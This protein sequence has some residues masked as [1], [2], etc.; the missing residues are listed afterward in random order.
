MDNSDTKRKSEVNQFK[1]YYLRSKLWQTHDPKLVVVFLI[2]FMTAL[3][4]LVVGIH[5]IRSSTFTPSNTITEYVSSLYGNTNQGFST[6][7]DELSETTQFQVPTSYKNETIPVEVNFYFFSNSYF[8]QNSL[9]E[10]NV[11]ATPGYIKNEL[12]ASTLTYIEVQFLNA[13]NVSPNVQTSLGFTYV[14]YE[15]F[16]PIYLYATYPDNWNGLTYVTFPNNGS[17]SC[18]VT[19]GIDPNYSNTSAY[20]TLQSYLNSE[21]TTFQNIASFQ[22]NF[23]E[24][25]VK[26]YLDLTDA[27]RSNLQFMATQRQQALQTILSALLAD[28]S[29]NNQGQANASE[30]MSIGLT[31]VIV[32]LALVDVSFIVYEHS[33]DDERAE[34]HRC[35]R[36]SEKY[37]DITY[38][39]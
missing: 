1:R 31:C 37:G 14:S 20:Q 22:Y 6:Q 30:N 23:S 10:V 38:C 12:N 9:F 25:Q 28:Q 32:F 3:G 11:T 29:Q 21:N 4:F 2:I 13:D 19:F 27:Q 34:K 8:S 26:S 36:E 5:F 7:P 39:V 33:K 18:N 17:I 24:V 15:Y 16:Y 35:Q